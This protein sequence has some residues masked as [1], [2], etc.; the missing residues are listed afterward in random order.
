RRRPPPIERTRSLP[1]GG[2][3]GPLG[4]TAGAKDASQIIPDSGAEPGGRNCPSA[5]ALFAGGGA[6][7]RLGGPLL[8]P[9]GSAAAWQLRGR[10]SCPGAAMLGGH[11]ASA[12]GGEHL[13]RYRRR[14]IQGYSR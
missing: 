13:Q 5:A 12:R 2:G 10:V 11:G 3:I 9:R 4:V 14:E 7:A 6:G 1:P 8:R